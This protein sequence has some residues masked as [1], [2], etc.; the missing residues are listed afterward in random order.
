MHVWNCCTRLAGNAGRKNDAKNRHLRTIA[1]LCRA[2]SSQLRSTIGKK[3]KQQYLLQM[4]S[5][6]GELRPTSGWGLLVSL[7]Q[8]CKFQRVLRLGSVTAGHSSSGRQPNVQRWTEGATYIRQSGH[9]VGHWPTFLVKT[10]IQSSLHHWSVG[11]LRLKGALTQIMSYCTFNV[12]NCFEKNILM[13][14]SKKYG[15][16]KIS[17]KGLIPKYQK[18]K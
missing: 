16:S 5:Q 12:V 14:V 8:P 4:S 1:Q 3:L 13:K 7:G 15:Y 2:I 6:Y 9:H 11:S 10:E 18:R 17:E